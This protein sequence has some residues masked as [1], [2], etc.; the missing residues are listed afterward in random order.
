MALHF[1]RKEFAQRQTRAREKSAEAGLDG[2]LIFRQESMYYLTGYDTSGYSM[3]QG[4]YLGVDGALALLTRSADQ[5]QSRITSVIEDIRI[6]ADQEG[7]NPGQDLRDMLESYGCRGKRI[8]VE[9]HAYGLTAQRGKM[10]DAAFDD[11]CELVDA[12]DIVR[13]LRL[14]KSPA[15]IEYIR[16]SG[17]LADEAL[18]VAKRMTVP[19]ANVGAIYGEMLNVIMRGDGD[20]SASRWPMGAGEEAL[21]IRY[22]T[23]HRNVGVDDQVQFEFA[24]SYRHYHTALMYVVLTGQVDPHQRD[25]FKACHQALM[26]C[27]E[28]LRPGNTVG[29]LFDLHARIL[30]EAGYDGHYMKAC[31]YTMGATYP[32][33]WM[34]WPM[35]YTGNPQVLEPNMVFF[36]H[37]VLLDSDTGLSMSLGETSV[38]TEGPCEQVTHAPREL[39]VN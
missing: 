9:Y 25:M 33:T 15:E 18:A 6:W 23:G 29:E 30:A 7:A 34:D 38:V 19:G 22:H 36:M 28:A 10:I 24:S 21:M 27:E 37:M 14:V 5:R 39:V 17:R 26:A 8:G 13:L 16:R 3:F 1:S 31:G 11:F 20:P 4:M 32:P 35:L 2:L 12:S